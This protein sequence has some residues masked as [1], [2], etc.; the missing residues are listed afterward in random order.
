LVCRYTC[1]TIFVILWTASAHAQTI[2]V[3]G[4]APPNGVTV[5]AA[6]SVSIAVSD[7]PGN[8]T[9]WIALFPVGAADSAYLHWSYLSGTTTPPASGLTA[10]TFTTHAPLAAGDYEWRLFAN[11]GSS[12]LATSSVVTVSASSAVLTVNGVAAPAVAIVG[13]GGS[14]TVSLSGGP[15]NP[16]DWIGLAPQGSPDATL[17]DWRYL[18]GTTVPPANGVTSGTVQFLAPATAGHYELRLFAHGTSGRLA[19]GAI[20]VSASTAALTVNDTAPP[21]AVPVHAGTY[22]N[23]E[24]TGGPAQPGDWVGLFAANA[25][26]AGHVA[27]RYL[28]G[29]T[30]LPSG[31]LSDASLIFSVP[32]AAGSYEFRF[33]N[34]NTLTRLATSTTMVVSASSA[35]LSVNGTAAPTSTTAAAGSQAV[36]SVNGGPANVG[37]WVGLFLAGA[38][39]AA[40]LDWR[41]LNDTAQVPGTGLSTATLH[42]GVPTTPG[43]YE[44]RFFTEGGG[45][46]LATSGPV[47]VPQT[48]AQISVNGV[49][50]PTPVT[51]A[52]GS[53]I[54]VE[55][56][57]GPANPTDWVALAVQGAPDS[58]YVA[59]QYLNGSSAPPDP[60]LS[61]GTVSFVL[62]AAAGVYEIRLFAHNSSQRITTS[63]PISASTESPAVTVTITSPFP[64]TTFNAPSSLSVSTSTS[65][66]G[67]TISRVDFFTGSALVGSS[68]VA[69]YA[70][71]WVSP[72]QGA[73]VLT[74]AVVDSTSTITTSAPIAITI[75][76]AGATAGTLGTPI[77]GPPGG[78]YGVG[79]VITLTA[80]AGTEIRYTLD[81]SEPAIGS[82]TYIAPLSIPGTGATVR[83]RAYR[84]GWTE[85]DVA[86]E[87]YQIDATPPTIVATLTPPPNAWGWNNTPVTVTFDCHDNVL[88]ASC[89]APVVVSEQ[90]A[91]QIINAIAFDSVGLSTGASVTI[92]LDSEPPTIVMTSPVSDI[93]T[94]DTS[95]ALSGNV[96]DLGSGTVKTI[97]NG[98]P[99]ELDDGILSCTVSLVPGRNTVII[100]AVDQ[101]D[102]VASRGIRATRATAA[103]GL[104][105]APTTLAMAVGDTWV[106]NVTTDTG[107][108]VTSVTWVSSDPDVL[109]IA[110]ENDGTI[111]AE[112]LGEVTVTA[113]HEGLSGEATIRVMPSGVAIGESI[114]TVA[115]TPGRYVA[116]L[117]RANPVLDDDP[118]LFAVESD[119]TTHQV[120]AIRAADGATL[121]IESVSDQPLPDAF[122]G[123]IV[124]AEG[125]P[126]PNYPEY[127][128]SAIRRIGGGGVAPWEY[129]SPAFIDKVAAAPDGTVYLIEFVPVGGSYGNRSRIVALDGQTG[130]VR[131]RYVLPPSTWQF[132]ELVDPGNPECPVATRLFEEQGS[133]GPILV[134][135]NGDAYVQHVQREQSTV[136][137]SA[138]GATG[139]ASDAFT[140]HLWHIRPQGAVTSHTLADW[141]ETWPTVDGW[142]TSVGQ[143]YFFEGDNHPDGNGGVLSYWSLIEY[144]EEETISESRTT[145]VGS[146]GTLTDRSGFAQ[147]AMV[148]SDGVAYFEGPNG[149]LMP[150]DTAT[151]AA[152]W[153]EP[154][155]VWPIEGRD[156]GGLTAHGWDENSM[157]IQEIDSTGQVVQSYPTSLSSPLVVVRDQGILHGLDEQ[158]MLGAVAAPIAAA[159]V[160][161]YQSNLFS[162]CNENV[163]FLQYRT[164]VGPTLTYGFDNSWSDKA[165]LKLQVLDALAL[166]SI[167]NQSVG[168]QVSF[169]PAPA[170]TT[171][172]VLF[173]TG[174]TTISPQTGRPRLAQTQPILHPAVQDQMERAE[175]VF[176]DNPAVLARLPEMWRKF[177]LH[178]I[179]H[180]MGLGD[181]PGRGGT[182]VMNQASTSTDYYLWMPMTVTACD[183]RRAKAAY[184]R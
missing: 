77:A 81:G 139:T 90:G 10:A 140:L 32:V 24:V 151:W 51:V 74:A 155:S 173:K 36:V 111:T 98:E 179:G 56:T 16:T 110:P 92:N 37:D 116:S 3:N 115:P 55:I 68:S 94:T 1:L 100:A 80:D 46:L 150:R 22:V 29:S 25:A 162:G 101:A 174:P 50:P 48:V 7:G 133:F 19:T 176:S 119:G 105:V 6:T 35:T 88:V 5:G 146:A 158:G 130:T 66:T 159:S 12:R 121:W 106:L 182:S 148:T 26:D 31:G 87:T 144:L 33:F 183:A 120:K 164:P 172:V 135:T 136:W 70:I 152:Q 71:D 65:I 147:P 157:L 181:L 73:H 15:G 154:L 113:T 177:A 76:P 123:F 34:A 102:N 23:V 42:F 61:S 163:P 18:D 78:V 142:H 169:A 64:G 97:C 41:Y 104:S 52:P 129:V 112:S 11:N 20:T 63:A 165:D 168:L 4:A 44:F 175:I 38:P 153:S 59:W 54:T 67:G 83:A 93:T 17:V 161:S 184:N 131:F 125:G 117:M 109:A 39:D 13:A 85:S 156:D 49:A 60:G 8:A 171:P 14:V 134:L 72:P 58:T 180:V 43:T 166:W 84:P 53:S 9:D 91:G 86:S 160:W 82:A 27:W 149:E 114:W 132:P 167:A 96:E 99:A 141:S 40:V 69:P 103:S 128:A 126:M 28:N 143:Q 178:E 57:G 2:T 122:G 89:P 170:N 107:M 79:Q 118:D 137:T 124:R 95:L 21:T 145:Q 30:T 62:P 108:P 127:S 138:C 75:G 45:G 47:V